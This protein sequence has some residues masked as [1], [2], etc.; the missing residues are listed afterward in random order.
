MGS[1]LV[2]LVHGPSCLMACGSSGPGIEPVYPA[3]AGGFQ[4]T[5]PPGMPN[6]SVFFRSDFLLD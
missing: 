6:D 1:R 5:G 2:V 3:L 4:A